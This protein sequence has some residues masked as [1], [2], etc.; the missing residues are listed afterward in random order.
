MFEIRY[1][2]FGDRELEAGELKGEEGYFE[3]KVQ[4]EAYGIFISED[5]DEFSVSIYWWFYYFLEA[6]IDLNITNYVL[7]SDIEKP[8]IWIELR[9]SGD[10][11][12]ISKVTGDKPV[13]GTALEKTP[14][15]N[16]QY[17]YWRDKTI[18]YRDL[19]EEVLDKGKVYLNTL[20]KLN[21]SHDSILNLERL[22]RKIEDEIIIELDH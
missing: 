7:I 12:F 13:G 15:P 16:I 6:I 3:F 10:E 22:V 21:Q 2:V 9:K 1:K 18:P 20:E 17:E 11:V 4:D 19:V 14:M 5:I 8:K